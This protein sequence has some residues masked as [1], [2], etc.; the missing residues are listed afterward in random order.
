MHLNKYRN[1]KKKK[2]SSFN[3]PQATRL[4]VAGWG[5]PEW[6][7]LGVL[8]FPIIGALLTSVIQHLQLSWLVHLF[9]SF[10]LRAYKS[11]FMPQSPSATSVCN[12]LITCCGQGGK[13]LCDFVECQAGCLRL[14]K[15]FP[16]L[17][18]RNTCYLERR[19]AQGV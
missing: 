16:S 1:V 3:Q 2:N 6:K 8:H 10:S 9:S 12:L 14:L 4:R 13:H 7:A 11:L 19:W 5:P 18:F 15:V 17:L